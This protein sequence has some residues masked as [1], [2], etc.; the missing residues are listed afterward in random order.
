MVIRA[1]TIQQPW[2]SAIVAGPK[3]VENRGRQWPVGPYMIHAG[4][5]WDDDAE[6][7]PVCR[8]WMAGPAVE[9]PSGAV[10]GVAT[11]VEC[12]RAVDGCCESPWGWV[13]DA[14]EV[15]RNYHLVLADVRALRRPVPCRGALGPWA[16]SEEIISA[17]RAEMMS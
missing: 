7:D 2:A 4:K 1:I 10:V 9:F 14:D 17:V 5:A 3:R 16:P 12:H 6:H 8:E 11:V 15:D 13:P